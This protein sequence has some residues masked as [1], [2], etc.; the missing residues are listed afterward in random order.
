M[1]IFLR[2]LNYILIYSKAFIFKAIKLIVDWYLPSSVPGTLKEYAFYIIFH[3]STLLESSYL[4]EQH[5]VE[6]S[7]QRIKII[8]IS[9]EIHRS[10]HRI[11]FNRITQC[12][13]LLKDE[14]ISRK[15]ELINRYYFSAEWREEPINHACQALVFLMA[16]LKTLNMQWWDAG[17]Y[18]W[19]I[20]KL[21]RI[22]FHFIS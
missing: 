14:W 12:Y 9:L 10:M 1:I 22:A 7:N 13:L 5:S 3:Y 15:T 16:C 8:A 6:F 2:M 19:T 18:E 4:I 21:L 11:M 17:Q 20:P